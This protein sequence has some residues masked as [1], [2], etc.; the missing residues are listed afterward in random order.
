MAISRLILFRMG[1]FFRHNLCKIWQQTFYVQKISSEN[2]TKYGTAGQATYTHSEFAFHD[3]IGFANGS[4]CYVHHL[5]CHIRSIDTNVLPTNCTVHNFDFLYI[6][7]NNLSQLQGTMHRFMQLLSR[8]W[9]IT[10]VWNEWHSKLTI[11]KITLK[12]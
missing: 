6:L 3:I 5:S 8:K 2:A 4:Q 10:Y 12:L 1:F 11:I 9:R 7:A